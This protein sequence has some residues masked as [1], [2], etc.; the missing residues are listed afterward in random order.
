M[1]SSPQNVVVISVFVSD[2]TI[3]VKNK[4][5]NSLECF[6]W[7]P[8]LESVSSQ[9]VQKA[10]QPLEAI[11]RMNLLSSTLLVIF[12]AETNKKSWRTPD[13]TQSVYSFPV[14]LIFQEW[15][16][17]SLIK[18]LHSIK[19][20]EAEGTD[21]DVVTPTPS[22]NTIRTST[23]GLSSHFPGSG[24]IYSDNFS[25]QYGTEAVPRNIYV[26]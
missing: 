3:T 13:V 21:T 1:C 22:K 7:L 26:C 17:K 12:R 16:L 19:L 8:E 6:L 14:Y 10:H 4:M 15:S 23:A 9:R 11:E 18:R 25:P 2:N 5:E 24:C 20:S